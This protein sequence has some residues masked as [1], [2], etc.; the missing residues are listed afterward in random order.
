[1]LHKTYIGER[2]E[3]EE[4]MKKKINFTQKFS[5]FSFWYSAEGA[6]KST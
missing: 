3:E 6:K 4:R 1:M 2:A 5:F